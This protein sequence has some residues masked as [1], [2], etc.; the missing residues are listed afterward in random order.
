MFGWRMRKAEEA[1]GDPERASSGAMH[2]ARA[3]E[4]TARRETQ[5]APRR[6]FG[7]ARPQRRRSVRP[8]RSGLRWTKDPLRDRGLM[9]RLTATERTHRIR[10]APARRPL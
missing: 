6:I 10:R 8:S 2:R 1:Q 3:E 4:R 5:R 9:A 7:F